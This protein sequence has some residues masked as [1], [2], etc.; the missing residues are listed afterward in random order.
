MRSRRASF[1]SPIDTH[2]TSPKPPPLPFQHVE[3]PE[4]P[5]PNYFHDVNYSPVSPDS[6]SEPSTDN[7]SHTDLTLDH[8]DTQTYTCYGHPLHRC[9]R[10]GS[11]CRRGDSTDDDASL[12]EYAESSDV[13]ASDDSESP[14]PGWPSQGTVYVSL[15]S[16]SCILILSQRL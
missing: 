10:L 1:L 2:P 12:D 3:Q 16:V 14:S 13:S 7:G 15:D 9:R 11:V 5:E 8:E 6:N 4:Q